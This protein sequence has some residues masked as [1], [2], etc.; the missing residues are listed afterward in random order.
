MVLFAK[1]IVVDIM[2]RRYLEATCTELYVNI[3]ILYHRYFST[4][5]RHHHMLAFEP[6]VLGV[7]GIDTHRRIAH[8]RLG[9]GGCHYGILPR[10]LFNH[11]AQVVEFALMLFENHLLVRKCRKGFGIPVNHAYSAVYKSF[12]IEVAE[13]FYNTLRAFLVHSECRTIPIT[14]ASEATQLLEYDTSVLF[15]PCPC[16]F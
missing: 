15:S 16:V 10:V 11:V 13:H 1:H 14:R 9:A 6:C 7:I 4:H 2:C 5:E 3:I 12:V 8:D